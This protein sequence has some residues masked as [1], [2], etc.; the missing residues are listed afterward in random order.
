MYVPGPPTVTLPEEALPPA[1]VPSWL[2]IGVWQVVSP[3]AKSWKVTLPPGFQP[4]DT[5]A[6][7]EAMPS[8]GTGFVAVVE[9]DGLALTHVVVAESSA[10]HGG[11]EGS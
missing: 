9:I 4:P 5:V 3:G 10:A 6:E 7:S 2:A 8:A 11:P 1:R